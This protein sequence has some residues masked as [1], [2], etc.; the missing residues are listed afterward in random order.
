MAW[1]LPWSR[2]PG[3]SP[4]DAADAT[5]D[6]WARHVAALVA[7]G[8]AEPGSAL[9]RGR[10]RPATQADHD[11]LY[12]ADQPGS[13]AHALWM[14]LRA[15]INKGEFDPPEQK[16]RILRAMAWFA[17]KYPSSGKRD[18][19]EYAREALRLARLLGAT[20]QELAVTSEF[21]LLLTD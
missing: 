21:S 6:A 14:E 18:A 10:R 1:S 11:A 9:G 16:I 13:R 17:N 12:G 15:N 8:V 19:R 7:Q 5:D 3:A 20:D 4:A 2:K